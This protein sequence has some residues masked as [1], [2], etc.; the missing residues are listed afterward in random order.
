M[1][2]LLAHHDLLR[3]RWMFL[4]LRIV[5]KAA[6][7]YQMMMLIFWQ[8]AEEINWWGGGWRKFYLLYRLM[9]SNVS[10][11]SW[12]EIRYYAKENRR[13]WRVW[14]SNLLRKNDGVRSLWELSKKSTRNLSVLAA[15]KPCLLLREWINQ[16]GAV[17]SATILCVS[18]V[19]WSGNLKKGHW[20]RVPLHRR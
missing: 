3:N 17:G 14:E 4:W 2:R 11:V 1:E 6:K 20:K 15:W 5:A 8:L 13:E 16:N 19:A 7:I 18:P 12:I 10:W 9:S